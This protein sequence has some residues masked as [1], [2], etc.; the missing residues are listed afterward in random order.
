M[1]YSIIMSK[2][3]LII[4]GSPRRHG[5][6]SAMADA[7][8]QGAR[9]SG[10]TIT[11]IALMDKTIGDCLGC[12][13]CQEN[14]GSCIQ[15][16]DMTEIYQAMNKADVIVLACPVY[17]YT[18]TSLMKRMIDRTFEIE[19]ALRNKTFYLLS[20]GAASEANYVQTMVDS[21]RQY[22]ACFGEAG[23]KEGG[24]FFAFGTRKP[25]DVDK[26]PVLE[27]VYEAGK[28]I[29]RNEVKRC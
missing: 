13:V 10:N 2:Q 28:R 3:I 7:F 11:E 19:H 14:G 26:M 5:N 22:I 27:E 25:S 15:K 12:A 29:E 17:F 6:T 4:K 24:I 16:D 8:A 18:W 21:F 9:E 23:G 20:A 1:W